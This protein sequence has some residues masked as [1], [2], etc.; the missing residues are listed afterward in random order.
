MN[1]LLTFLRGKEKIFE[2]EESLNT[3]LYHDIIKISGLCNNIAK[4]L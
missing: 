2:L 1:Y 4:S 3:G